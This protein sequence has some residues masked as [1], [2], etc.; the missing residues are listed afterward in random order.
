MSILKR[1]KNIFS[2]NMNAALDTMEDPEKMMNQYIRNLEK[3]LGK[4][5]DSTADAMVATEKCHRQ[6]ESCKK[7][8]VEITGYEKAAIEAENE[9][10]AKAFAAARQ[11]EELRLAEY[12][13]AASAADENVAKLR[14]MHDELAESLREYL[15]KEAVLKTKVD[16]V[17]VRKKV[18]AV[19]GLTLNAD[20]SIAGFK[21]ME[22][23][24]DD[25]LLK[26]KA[27]DELSVPKDTLKELK[28]KYASS[29]VT[30]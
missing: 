18:S 9:E 28:A 5:K 7:V 17:N 23:H 13:S 20:D 19:R 26:A 6:V 14:A 1:I 24:I 2:A 8:I 29:V 30:A 21:R 10:D 27:L 12:E 16:V 11:N 3:D 25:M 22:E 4:V 15:Q